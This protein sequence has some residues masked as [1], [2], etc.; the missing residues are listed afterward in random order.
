MTDR[1]FEVLVVTPSFNQAAYLGSCIRSVV[2]QRIDGLRYVVVDGGSDDGSIEVLDRY[3][4]RIDH[5]VVEPDRGQSDAIVKGIGDRVQGWFGWINS[6]DRYLPGTL[7]RVAVADA[8]GVDLLAM[9]IRVVGDGPEYLMENRNLDARTMLLDGDYSMAQPGLFF[10]LDRL[11][12]CGGID[13]S[14]NYG[15]DWD[16]LVRYLAT[17]P[18]IR[19]D[20]HVAAEFTVHPDSKTSVERGRGI[21]NRFLVENDRI[22]DKLEATLRPDLAAASRLGRRRRD[23]HRR[24]VERLDDYEAS[25]AASAVQL[26]LGMGRDPSAAAT[27]RTAAAVV[28]LLS[29]YVRPRTAWQK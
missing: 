8:A 7:E 18:T 11:R 12:R 27:G 13:T 24:I 10:R 26:L 22:R 2:D 5:V 17:G 20:D 23:W 4:D 14:L 3:R 29:R 9:P 28:R 16:L 25:P 15:F 21:E 1:T 6:D 19:Y